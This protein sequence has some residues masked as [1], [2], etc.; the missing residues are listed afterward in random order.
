[1]DCT[2]V[3]AK[4]KQLALEVATGKEAWPSSSQPEIK[5]D[6]NRI[7]GFIDVITRDLDNVT[8]KYT[9]VAGYATDNDALSPKAAE[10]DDLNTEFEKTVEDYRAFISQHVSA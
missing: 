6:C 4:L 1:M 3:Q 9:E 5:R 7:D 10:I 2:A 8:K